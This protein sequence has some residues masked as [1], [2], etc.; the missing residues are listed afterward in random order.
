MLLMYFMYDSAEVLRTKG[1]PVG[2]RRD[3]SIEAATRGAVIC[4]VNVKS[5]SV[6]LLG[7]DGRAQAH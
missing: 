5:S 7:N 6:V 1:F 3:S 2:E 4:H